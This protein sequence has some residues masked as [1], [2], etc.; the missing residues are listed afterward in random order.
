MFG[1][2]GAEWLI[3]GGIIVLLFVPSAA[4]FAVGYFVG[5]RAGGSTGRSDDDV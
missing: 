4:F 2:G 1:I 5:K 3:I